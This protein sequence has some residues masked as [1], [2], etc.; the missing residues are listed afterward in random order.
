MANLF[1]AICFIFALSLS[2]NTVGQCSANQ[3]TRVSDG[4]QIINSDTISISHAG[5]VDSMFFYCLPITYPYFVGY[6]SQ[7]GSGSG[8]FTFNFNPPVDSVTLNFSGMDGDSTSMEEIH[9][10]VNGIHYAIPS[11]GIS[12]T[13]DALAILTPAGDIAA[14]NPCYGSGWRGTNIPGVVNSL[15]VLDTVLRGTPNGALF[16]IY[17]CNYLTDIIPLYQEKDLKVYPNPV[18]EILTIESKLA[19]AEMKIFDVLGNEIKKEIITERTQIDVGGL[20][21]GL[22]QMRISTPQGLL[23][24]KIIIQH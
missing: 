3:I 13:C 4:I 15:T 12:N 17:F 14:C 20:S 18:N 21:N 22:Y 9:L 8:S 11:A 19:D 23:T 16:S 10:F 6:N 2:I 1:K 5:A 24:K 7:L